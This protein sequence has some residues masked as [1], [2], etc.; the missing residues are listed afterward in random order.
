[1]LL[2]STII[3]MA[4]AELNELGA[5]RST[6]AGLTELGVGTISDLLNGVRPPTN[7]HAQL[8]YRW[9]SGL[10]RYV[11]AVQP[12]PVDFKKITALKE[13]ITLLESGRLRVSVVIQEP[14]AEKVEVWAVQFRSG[15]YFAKARQ[16]YSNNLEVLCSMNIRDAA[17][18]AGE[19]LARQALAAL[20][21]LGR[22]GKV[23]LNRFP[24]PEDS[25][26]LDIESTGLQL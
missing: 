5:T 9:L 4:D 20:E 7:E 25:V 8:I 6:I 24:P 1:M 21:K 22:V 15:S 19:P 26:F 16:N 17:N 3:A 13:Q 10:R 12:I 11:E 14:R 2:P 23:V 18:Y